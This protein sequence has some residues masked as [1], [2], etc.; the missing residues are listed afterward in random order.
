M[1][2]EV[3]K[4]VTLEGVSH[5][6]SDG[7]PKSDLTP[8]CRESVSIGRTWTSESENLGLQQPDQLTMSLHDWQIPAYLCAGSLRRPQ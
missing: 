7:E 2:K 8:R 5:E 6:V 1:K 3:Y 4:G